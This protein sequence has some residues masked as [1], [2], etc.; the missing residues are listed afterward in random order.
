MT[1][2]KVFIGD[3][4]K[5]EL[6]ARLVN[7]AKKTTF[8]MESI[9][10][11]HMTKADA[12][13]EVMK[14]R[15]EGKPLYFEGLRGRILDIDL[16]S[17]EMDCSEYDRKNERS[18]AAIVIRL[19]EEKR[20][21]RQMEIR[22][23]MRPAID[24]IPLATHET[25]MLSYI[26]S[27]LLGINDS[28]DP[29]YGCSILGSGD[30]RH[31]ERLQK[32]W[33]ATIDMQQIA[34]YRK[35]VARSKRVMPP[36]DRSQKLVFSLPK[37]PTNEQISVSD[38]L[39]STFQALEREKDLESIRSSALLALEQEYLR[40]HGSAIGE[41]E[42][43]K[44]K[45]K[46]TYLSLQASLLNI[47]Q[48]PNDNVKD[49][50]VA[51]PAFLIGRGRFTI[52]E[53]EKFARAILMDDTDSLALYISKL[54]G[55]ALGVARLISA[56]IT[57]D[58]YKLYEVMEQ[59]PQEQ[60]FKIDVHHRMQ[61]LSFLPGGGVSSGSTPIMLAVATSNSSAF[62]LLVQYSGIIHL[63]IENDAGETLFKL[64]LCRLATYNHTLIKD[65][66]YWSSCLYR[67][68]K[69]LPAYKQSVTEGLENNDFFEGSS[70]LALASLLSSFA[71][72]NEASMQ[73][74][75]HCYAYEQ[76]WDNA[77][78]GKIDHAINSAIEASTK[79]IQSEK[80]FSVD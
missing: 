23:F 80:C 5:A 16:T 50:L 64:A 21:S 27:G 67:Y 28:P 75:A 61:D 76:Q 78:I 43:G 15:K 20:D 14:K 24:A 70:V 73:E 60:G 26:T 71:F 7:C 51:K 38:E 39:Q 1:I 69:E 59:Q 32:I 35:Q 48:I 22:N 74:L 45:K 58:D 46:Q 33:P 25:L 36:L 63:D 68:F 53:I 12:L 44:L 77:A 42:H 4:D 29:A 41:D 11:A 8:Y 65:S 52:M 72:I 9:D 19:R 31:S 56:I 49:S 17:E 55:S 79:D 66:T 13:E 3:L 57:R 10:G 30:P 2:T 40:F 54:E 37:G 47:A 34:I 18:A 62:R 6:L